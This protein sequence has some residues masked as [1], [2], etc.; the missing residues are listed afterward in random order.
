M[1]ILKPENKLI[2]PVFIGLSNRSFRPSI[3]KATK[4]LM[5]VGN[6]TA[7]GTIVTDL[8]GVREVI[9][10]LYFHST[11]AL[12]GIY[13]EKLAKRTKMNL[14]KFK[15]LNKQQNSPLFS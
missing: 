6:H 8:C 13:P 15:K 2:T 5:E 9:G 12:C 7:R 1:P 14:K 3:P 10:F 11:E 4:A